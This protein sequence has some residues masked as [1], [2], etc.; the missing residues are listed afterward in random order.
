[1]ARVSKH[2]PENPVNK[3]LGK[4][5]GGLIAVTFFSLAI[6]LL[7]L[8][9]SLYMLQVFDRVLTSRSVETLIFL[10]VI[11][12]FAF[13]VLFGLEVIRGQIMV[14]IA[15][16]LE[17]TLSG[18]MFASSVRVALAQR[19]ASA[20]SIRDLTTFKSFLS[21]PALFPIL[22]APWTPIFMAAVFMLHPYLGWLGLSGAILLLILALLNEFATKTPLG[23]ANHT[24]ERAMEEAQ[25]AIRNAGTIEAMG[26]RRSLS[27]RWSTGTQLARTVS[28]T[29]SNRSGAI[30]SASKFFRQ[31]LQVLMLGTGAWLV[32]QNELSPGG[33][34]ASSI[35]IARALAPVDQAINSWRSAVSARAALRRMKAIAEA[36]LEPNDPPP[37]PAPKGRL[38]VEGVS[39]A[40]PNEKS[41]SLRNVNFKLD[42]GTCLG[43]VGPTSAGK[44]TLGRLMVGILVPRIGHVRLDGADL[45]TWASADRGQYIGYLPQ[46]IELFSGTVRDNIARMNAQ[47]DQ[48][49]ESVYAAA[50]AAGIHE[51]ILGFPEGYETE[52][53]VDGMSLSGGQRQKLAL[54]RA[55]YGD[56]K[57]LVFDE[58]NSNLDMEGENA[59]LEAISRLKEEGRTVVIIAHRSSILRVVDQIMVLKSGAIEMMGPRNEVIAQLNG[60]GKQT[61]PWPGPQSL[62]GPGLVSK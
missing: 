59:L 20:Q 5:R 46:D 33:M 8:T 37:L 32:L 6:N 18:H 25:S 47:A 3:A 21:G 24:Y 58:P 15:N 49:G 43:V 9:A 16:W 41:A 13:I 30:S 51:E 40:H 42:P 23:Q 10:T 22:D 28:T 50:R 60:D 45:G 38:S 27:D 48:T 35:L 31:L 53:G 39:Y 17:Q 19:G 52:I 11:A 36:T 7:M 55:I 4:C 1:M 62:P 26:L 54:A 34:I 12:G 56:P 29:A 57:L 2:K 14:K 44:S 61:K